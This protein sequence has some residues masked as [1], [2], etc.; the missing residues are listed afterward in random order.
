M[1]MALDEPKQDDSKLEGGTFTFLLAPRDREL[2]EQIGGVQVDYI[3]SWRGRGFS[4][5]TGLGSGRC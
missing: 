5:S 2:L 1:G 3:D 4:L